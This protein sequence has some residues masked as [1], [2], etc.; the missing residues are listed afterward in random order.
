MSEYKIK[1][2]LKLFC[3]DLTRVAAASLLRLNRKTF[4]LNKSYFGAKKIR[5]KR[6]IKMQ[7]SI[8]IKI[9]LITTMLSRSSFAMFQPTLSSEFCTRDKNN[10]HEVSQEMEQSI[11]QT[12]QNMMVVKNLNTDSLRCITNAADS[13]SSLRIDHIAVD[14]IQ[15]FP[16][17]PALKRLILSFTDILANTIATIIQYCQ[18]LE[19]LNVGFCEQAPAGIIQALEIN[20]AALQHLKKLVLD[21]TYISAKQ[22]YFII[23]NCPHLKELTV[24][25]CLRAPEGIIEALEEN[26]FALQHLKK[27][28][29]SR[30]YTPAK[31]IYAIITN[32]PQLEELNVTYCEQASTV[33]ATALKANQNI[34]PNLKKLI[35]GGTNIPTEQIHTILQGYP[36]LEDLGV[37]DCMQAP[38]AIIQELI[39][40]P[41]ALQHLKR[42]GFGGTNISAKQIHTIIQQLPHLEELD[43][44][45][46]PQAPEGI[47]EALEENPLALQYLKR[48]D[49]SWTDISANDIRSIIQYCPQLEELILNKCSRAFNGIV[50]ELAVNQNALPNLKMLVLERPNFSAEERYFIQECIPGVEMLW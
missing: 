42:L 13:L 21:H 7:L 6:G 14:V 5:K 1:K 8:V 24:T 16:Y 39:A 40:N 4:E 34:L 25:H 12:I 2:I 49:L 11:N 22:M 41:N 36:Q 28:D 35:F 29:L 31:Q 15:P 30:T 18:Q 3:E 37:N 26:S 38:A 32:C 17:L 50:R 10:L 46:C 45:D 48:L 23:K 43:V 47:I 9:A 33:I 20:P 44:F 27:L 19:E